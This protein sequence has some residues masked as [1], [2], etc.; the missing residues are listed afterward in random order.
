M[1]KEERFRR[2]E[3]NWGGYILDFKCGV[4]GQNRIK[5]YDWSVWGRSSPLTTF[6]TGFPAI[7]VVDLHYGPLPYCQEKASIGMPLHKYW[8]LCF[9]V[10]SEAV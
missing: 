3:G 9:Y 1:K 7:K 8:M 5:Q 4:V 10:G 6:V 2:G